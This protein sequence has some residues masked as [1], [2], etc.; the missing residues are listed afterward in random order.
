MKKPDASSLLPE[1]RLLSQT[2]NV[3]WMNTLLSAARW[4]RG[5]VPACKTGLGPQ[6]ALRTRSFSAP[7]VLGHWQGLYHWPFS[8]HLQLVGTCLASDHAQHVASLHV[9]I[10]FTWTRSGFIS[11]PSASNLALGLAPSKDNYLQIWGFLTVPSSLHMIN[12]ASKFRSKFHEGLGT[13]HLPRLWSLCVLS[14]EEVPDHGEERG[15][16]ISFLTQ[17]FPHGIPE[18]VGSGGS[19]FP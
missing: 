8:L 2:L 6:E 12:P 18:G 7:T 3:S 13:K 19:F 5:T 11:S 14:P 4:H 10:R 15:V 16:P 1:Y 17:A 9:I